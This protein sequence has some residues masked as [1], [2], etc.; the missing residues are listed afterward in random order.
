ME[1]YLFTKKAGTA[2]DCSYEIALEVSRSTSATPPVEKK[3]K[4]SHSTKPQQPCY[5]FKVGTGNWGGNPM[6]PTW[7]PWETPWTPWA[8]RPP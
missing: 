6:E 1:Q 8:M 5:I 3:K 7:A 4:A 2:E